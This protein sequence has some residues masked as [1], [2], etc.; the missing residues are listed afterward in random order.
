[1]ST[2]IMIVLIIYVIVEIFSGS[3]EQSHDCLKCVHFTTGDSEWC[4]E[5]DGRHFERIEEQ[6]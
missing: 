6:E 1:M 5:C 4:N 2:F 3:V